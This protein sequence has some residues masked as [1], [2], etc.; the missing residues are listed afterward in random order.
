MYPFGVV[1]QNNFGI[2]VLCLMLFT[3]AIWFA[4]KDM[5]T[6]DNWFRGFPAAWNLVAPVMFLLAPQQKAG[7]QVSWGTVNVNGETCRNAS[8]I[9]FGPPGEAASPALTA[10]NLSIMICNSGE[11]DV[12]GL[13]PSN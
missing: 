6:E 4:R 10:S 3:G 9:Q 7:F 13:A 8:G 12:S 11:L 5:M 2:A 1:P